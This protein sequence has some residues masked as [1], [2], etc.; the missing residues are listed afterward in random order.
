[1]SKDCY[2][3]LSWHR[4]YASYQLEVV[5]STRVSN[6]PLLALNVK[7]SDADKWL[8]AFDALWAYRENM[9]W[10]KKGWGLRFD[11]KYRK[12]EK[13]GKYF[14]IIIIII[15]IIVIPTPAL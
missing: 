7:E 14:I 3:N 15:V 10:V 13:D 6:S 2:F 11:Q 12:Q 9:L 1:V 5:N 4:K 8:L